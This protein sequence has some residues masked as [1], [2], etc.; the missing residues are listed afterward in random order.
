MGFITHCGSS[1]VTFDVDQSH[2][3][4]VRD[5]A[6]KGADATAHRRRTVNI[7]TFASRVSG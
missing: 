2:T 1:V 6:F 7:V 3:A 5:S 4:E